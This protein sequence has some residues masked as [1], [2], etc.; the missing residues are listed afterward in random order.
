MANNF[1]RR[2]LRAA[3]LALI[4]AL[5]AW[6]VAALHGIWSL[7]IVEGYLDGGRVPLY[8]TIPVTYT[9]FFLQGAVAP[10]VAFPLILIWCSFAPQRFHLAGLFVSWLIGVWAAAENISFTFQI[11]YG[12][13]WGAGEAIRALFYH[14]VVTHFALVFGLLGVFTLTRP[15]R[16]PAP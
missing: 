2:V 12:T 1:L 5:W 13:T 16:A 3:L 9:E 6:A 4:T 14:P 10:V 8:Q 7:G 15:F 11:D